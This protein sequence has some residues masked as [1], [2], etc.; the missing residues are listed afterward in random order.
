[1]RGLRAGALECRE[2]GAEP[3]V[4]LRA[5][6]L[7]EEGRQG[8][9]DFR[10]RVTLLHRVTGIETEPRQAAADRRRDDV[11]V[12]HARLAAL[13]YLDGQGPPPDAGNVHR[14]GTR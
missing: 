2:G 6:A 13:D 3:G 7:V 8:R 5:G 11:A 12:L 10:E 14:D 9:R 4:T 1:A